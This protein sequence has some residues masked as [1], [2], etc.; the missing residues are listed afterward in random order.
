M[1]FGGLTCT[2]VKVIAIACGMYSAVCAVGCELDNVVRLARI[3]RSTDD[4][5]L[6]RVC[7]VLGFPIKLLKTLDAGV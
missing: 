7:L 2:K 6:V 3:E 5:D 1:Y 4:T